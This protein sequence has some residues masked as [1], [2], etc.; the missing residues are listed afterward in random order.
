MGGIINSLYNTEKRRKREV[1]PARQTNIGKCC[2]TGHCSCMQT[3]GG[4]GLRLADF[5]ALC[6]SVNRMRQKGSR[7]TRD[8]REGE[9]ADD[10]PHDSQLDEKASI[11]RRHH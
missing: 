7:K 9:G 8:K 5:V 2:L 4:F 10:D 6:A 11:E 1:L 3:C